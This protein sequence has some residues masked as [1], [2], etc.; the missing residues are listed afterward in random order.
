MSKRISNTARAKQLYDRL[1]E[2]SND[3]SLETCHSR[4]DLSLMLGYKNW[5]QGTSWIHN[6]IGRGYL[7]ENFIYGDYRY[8]LICTS[9]PYANIKLGRPC[10]SKVKESKQERGMSKETLD[11]LMVEYDWHKNTLEDNLYFLSF[12]T[13]LY[14]KIDVKEINYD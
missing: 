6:Q 5:H 13:E 2:L 11:Q 8:T 14:S 10:K 1:I 7:D 3:G 9:N 4:K 12:M